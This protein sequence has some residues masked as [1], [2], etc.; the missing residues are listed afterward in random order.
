MP[1]RAGSCS[2][3]PVC[4]CT[5]LVTRAVSPRPKE[6]GL[7]I[8]RVRAPRC[9]R[10][11]GWENHEAPWLTTT[12]ISCSLVFGAQ[13]KKGSNAPIPLFNREASG[14]L[15]RPGATPLR[16]AKGGDSG[17]HCPDARSTWCPGLPPSTFPA[18]ADPQPGGA[19]VTNMD[20]AGALAAWRGRLEKAVASLDYPG[21]GC[22]GAWRAADVGAYLERQTA[23]QLRYNRLGYNEFIV[24]PADA[25]TRALPKIIGAFYFS[26]KS[27]A[28]Y[29]SHARDAHAR[30]LAAFP[31]MESRVPLLRMD[32]DNWEAPFS[33]AAEEPE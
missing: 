19:D 7:L 22:G 21:D 26:S 27:N 13:H 31:A 10:A 9:T 8:S 2:P 1:R 11:D 32:G 25:W 30:F 33:A 12:D 15:L 14:L 29:R 18:W 4:W 3:T 17:G 20:D 24:G 23:W 16:C 5:P 6:G 28:N